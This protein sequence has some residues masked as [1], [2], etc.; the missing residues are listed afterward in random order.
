MKRVRHYM[1]IVLAVAM[2]TS[3]LSTVAFADEPVT[4]ETQVMQFGEV[5]EEDGYGGYLAVGDSQTRGMGANADSRDYDY[6]KK[7]V[8]NSYPAV[9]AQTVGCDDGELKTAFG[10]TPT[11]YWPAAFHGMTVADF[12]D[13]LG[14]KDSYKDSKGNIIPDYHETG[15]DSG[16]YEQSLKIYGCAS[17][18][19][20]DP[21]NPVEVPGKG[22]D[23]W[24]GIK[25]ASLITLNLGDGDV[26][27]RALTL[28]GIEEAGKGIS[29]ITDI[30]G[31]SSARNRVVNAVKKVRDLMDEGYDI[32]KQLYPQTIEAIRA[33][34]PKATIVLV[35]F[36]NPI[37]GTSLTGNTTYDNLANDMVGFDFSDVADKTFAKMNNDCRKWAKK[38]NGIFVDISG[39]VTPMTNNKNGMMSVLTG[40]KEDLVVGT[41][42]TP[43]GHAYMT[44]RILS[45]LPREC[46][47]AHEWAEAYEADETGHWHKCNY[48]DVKGDFDVHSFNP[49]TGLCTVCNYKCTHNGETKGACE[50][51]G[52]EDVSK[53]TFD[54]YEITS[55]ELAA[56][57]LHMFFGDTDAG[58]FEFTRSGNSWR[59]RSVEENQYLAVTSGVFS[60]SDSAYGWTYS[61]N[62]FET[63]VTTTTSSSGSGI[64][65]I[66]GS[67]FGL[68]NRQTTT[69][70][71]LVYVD[72]G[73]EIS[74]STTNARVSFATK[75]KIHQHVWVLATDS[76]YHWQECQGCGVMSEAGKKKH[77]FANGECTDCGYVCKH[78]DVY[79]ADRNQHWIECEN[80]D[81][82]IIREKEN[83][84]WINGECEVCGYDCDHRGATFGTCSN[85]GAE[86]E[87]VDPLNDDTTIP[88]QYGEV[89]AAGRG[90]YVAFGDSNMRGMGADD[91][92]TTITKTE[93]YMWNDYSYDANIRAVGGVRSVTGAAPTIV[94]KEIGCDEGEPQKYFADPDISTPSD[95]WPIVAQAL[96]AGAA[97]DLLGIEDGCYDNDLYHYR[98]FT[99]PEYIYPKDSIPAR[100]YDGNYGH[101]GF[102][103]L[104]YNLIPLFGGDY[105]LDSTGEKT[106]ISP[107]GQSADA[108]KSIEKAKLITLNFGESEVF[109]RAA[110]IA[111]LANLDLSAGKETLMAQLA[112]GVTELLNR[113][114]EG[115]EQWKDTY[116]EL[117]ESIIERNPDAQKVIVGVYN[118]LGGTTFVNAK[119]LLT[120]LGGVI[121]DEV[122]PDELLALYRNQLSNPELTKDDILDSWIENPKDIPDEGLKAGIEEA[123]DMAGMIKSLNLEGQIAAKFAQMNEDCM[124]MADKYDCIYVD[125]SDTETPYTRDLRN[126]GEPTPMLQVLM[127]DMG[128]ADNP[129]GFGDNM[130]R[131]SHP[132]PD[133][134]EYMAKQIL[135]ALPRIC[136][137]HATIEEWTYNGDGTHSGKCPKCGA[138]VSEACYYENHVCTKC[139]AGEPGVS[140]VTVSFVTG[141]GASE[142]PES[143][144]VIAGEGKAIKPASPSQTGYLFGFWSTDSDAVYGAQDTEAA[145]DFDKVVDEDIILYA[146]WIK[147]T[148]HE[149]DEDG[150]CTKC[151]AA[152]PDSVVCEYYKEVSL[153]N[154]ELHLT[155]GGRDA[156]EYEFARV[157]TS[158]N[159]WSIMDKDGNY[160]GFAN[161][162]FT[163]Q[164][165]PFSW[166]YSNGRFS[167]SVTTTTT[168]SSRS[169]GGIFGFIGSIFG[170]G[171]N[172]RRT[173][174]TT[175]TYYLTYSGTG[176]QVS[177]N[178][179]GSN[180][181]FGAWTQDKSHSF[182]AW[183]SN[184]DGTHSRVCEKCKKEEKQECKFDEHDYKCETC[185]YEN[186]DFEPECIGKATVSQVS[187]GEMTF[188]LG[189]NDMGE[190]IF[191]RSGN[192]W[193]IREAG[194]GGQYVG[195]SNNSVRMQNNA[196][197]WTFNNG[198]FRTSV[199]TT[200][201]TG[202]G[203]SGGIFGWIG[204]IFGGG[205]NNRRTTTTTTTYYLVCRNGDFAV[206]TDSSRSQCQFVKETVYDFHEFEEGVCIHCG[207]HEETPNLFLNALQAEPEI[208]AE[209]E[210][211]EEIKEEIVEI[212]QEEAEITEEVKEEGAELPQEEPE[213]AEEVVEEIKEEITEDIPEEQ[214]AEEVIEELPKEEEGPVEE[215]PEEI[216]VEEEFPKEV[217]EE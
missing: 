46:V 39:T 21:A 61:N 23:I 197:G 3:S 113:M 109:F 64:L 32:W 146:C 100:P 33:V 191:A 58:E 36:F 200:T 128:A 62:R 26:F 182:G 69:R 186:P 80:C 131:Y 194:A 31:N 126:N 30:I 35:G 97:N 208:A 156:G 134:H 49:E 42:P 47:G 111:N 199:T 107:K 159:N 2:M 9:I 43:D 124:D 183:K 83:H 161:N 178:T 78:T 110:T 137:E 89:D 52:M 211:I 171:N 165:S 85:C 103:R 55:A 120:A 157:G 138:T 129:S 170:G 14:I 185:G 57:K 105:S 108:W 196:F 44:E 117:I 145:Y 79:T 84:S 158:G 95:F 40:G 203:N 114:E 216:P 86:L 174:T 152:D 48:C 176:F 172:N 204:S 154:E 112:A 4:H 127:W 65:G 118:P 173:T 6:D 75:E 1:A 87:G 121:A 115:Y 67:L 17:S 206:S 192:N 90:G 92:T 139:G 132:T 51:C 20:R 151:G 27:L 212:P 188:I 106:T 162:R 140:Y 91:G 184:N 210:K 168:T 135:R 41:H 71:Y 133:G 7:I 215:K 169:S 63:S 179:S 136:K 141:E 72:G 38:Y 177:T 209:E 180:A 50:I 24:E 102:E 74:T 166:N 148:D 155:L 37:R 81:L 153:T 96:T 167:T 11:N 101:P 150:I 99:D 198:S 125:I 130:D 119:L 12:N 13:L 189:G 77:D 214:P 15:Y 149:Y 54:T 18:Y 73:F 19:Q 187:A 147:C 122:V 123:N 195:F 88:V 68:G 164:S 181:V 28:S 98:K 160:L 205:N 45:A 201:T 59:I 175:T 163:L 34:N 193:T 53:D 56:G 190:Y 60:Y 202:G 76:E 10:D 144:T 22:G 70:Y 213:I 143:Q 5:D 16:F 104:D 116:P 94:A 25:N 82:G 207:E 217:S 93:A 29:G 8:E 66:L 142:A